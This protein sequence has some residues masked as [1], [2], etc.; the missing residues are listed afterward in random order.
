MRGNLEV[1][2]ILFSISLILCVVN[3]GIR[4]LCEFQSYSLSFTPTVPPFWTV[5]GLPCWGAA[6][7]FCMG[8]HRPE[9]RHSWYNG[10]RPMTLSETLLSTTFYH[11]HHGRCSSDK[12][13][14]LSRLIP[15]ANQFSRPTTHA[16][17]A[18]LQTHKGSLNAARE[19]HQQA[20]G[21]FAQAAKTT[22]D[23]EAL[24]LLKLLEENHRELAKALAVSKNGSIIVRPSTDESSSVKDS[25][26]T[27]RPP[28][29]TAKS[30]PVTS[31]L[32]RPP[33]REL[34][35]SIASNLATARGKPPHEREREQRERQKQQQQRGLPS[36]P[37]VTVQH[38]GGE[39]HESETASPFGH[40]AAAQGGRP[41]R[42]P[43]P[44]RSTRFTLPLRPYSRNCPASLA[45]AGL[46]LAQGQPELEQQARKSRTSARATNDP[47][48]S[49]I[50]SAGTLR[51][52]RED[53]G[54]GFGAHESFYGR[55]RVA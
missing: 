9:R 27:L 41:R 31:P 6:V 48:L 14:S 7:R 21:D 25:T 53:A 3:N 49:T 38:A 16:R 5:R 22:D 8:E 29:D 18:A 55:S 45:F 42:V 51:A 44:R 34:A 13:K 30:T 1:E 46:P 33:R 23:I 2:N 4:F 47:D 24:R 26:A 12:R 11:I 54:Q 10:G 17:T 39:H 37:E 35:S 19:S 36:T 32:R 50:F 40:S 15:P 43:R 52:V 20:A 28:S